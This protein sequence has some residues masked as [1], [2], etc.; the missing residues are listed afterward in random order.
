M[1]I[2]SCV[3]ELK[4]RGT[5]QLYRCWQKCHAQPFCSPSSTWFW[6]H[7]GMGFEIHH[8]VNISSSESGMFD[9]TGVLACYFMM[10]ELYS[11]LTS[12]ELT[13]WWILIR[14]QYARFRTEFFFVRWVWREIS[15]VHST[16]WSVRLS[17]G[18][19]S[20][21]KLIRSPK[22]FGHTVIQRWDNMTRLRLFPLFMWF[23]PPV[24]SLSS[25]TLSL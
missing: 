23:W 10:V 5:L 21:H 24:F 20:Y 8:P 2:C 13:L 14:T 1:C 16:W 22:P 6:L 11:S 25:S 17:I 12:T 18:Y 19:H 4:P 15:G 7:L 3:S 9:A